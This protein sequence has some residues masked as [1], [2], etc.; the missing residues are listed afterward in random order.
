MGRGRGPII[1]HNCQYKGHYSRE[2]PQP[3]S[4]CMY[5]RAIYHVTE[6]F[7][8]LMTKIWEKRNLNNQNVQWIAEK[9]R[10]PGRNINILTIGGVKTGGDADDKKKESQ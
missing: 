8:K 9:I 7:P 4:T 2:F 3:A 6:E 5:R 1:F 10:N